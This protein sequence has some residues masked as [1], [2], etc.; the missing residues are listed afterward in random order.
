MNIM[1]LRASNFYGGPER[2][3]HLHALR[4]ENTNYHLHICSFSE[5]NSEPEFLTVIGNDN[6]PTRTFEV[7]NAYDFSVIKKLKA[8]VRDQQV[9]LLCTHDYRT[10]FFGLIMSF[11]TDVKWVAFSRGWTKDNHR[12]RLFHAMDKLIIRFAPKIVAVSRAQKQKLLK[13]LISESKIAVIHNA[14]DPEYFNDVPRV[15]IRSEFKFPPDSKVVI[16][17]GR[18]SQEKGQLYLVKAATKAVQ[19][20]SKLRF[21]LFG[22][23]PDF[24]II[25][26]AVRQNNLDDYVICPGFRKNLLSYI[27]DSDIL[28]NPSLSEGLPNIVLEAMALRVPVVATSV[29]GVPEIISEG[30]S[31]YLVDAAD[32]DNLADKIVSL[33]AD[34]E[35]GRKFADEAYLTT[36]EKLSFAAQYDKM[37][38]LYKSFGLNN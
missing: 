3:I 17:G 31:G 37:V 22:T 35:L 34:P 27:K 36:I 8:F 23:G 14:I 7:N 1:H 5:N 15:D 13:L 11:I 18:F 16:C 24:E 9:D 28:V 25:N 29:G 20:N 10:N 32:S 4:C 6:I 38:A 12:V 19:N 30:Q 2:Q 21:V 26:K 33:A